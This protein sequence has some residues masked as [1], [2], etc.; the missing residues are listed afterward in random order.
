MRLENWSIRTRDSGPYT[1]PEC[2]PTHLCGEVYG[3]PRFA[4]GE[5]IYSSTVIKIEGSK[6]TTHN[7]VYTLGKPAP[8][9]VK[10]C[11]EHG[12]HIPTTQKP[13]EVKQAPLQGAV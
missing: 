11:R 3:H 10:W 7:S 4:D 1:A 9:Y 2:L 12:G 8:D 13:I 5:V 6:I